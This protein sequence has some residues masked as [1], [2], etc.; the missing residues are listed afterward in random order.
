MSENTCEIDRAAGTFTLNLETWGN[1][2]PLDTLERWLA[3][4]REQRDLFPKS[5]NSYDKTIA[6]LENALAERD[7]G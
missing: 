6:L 7:G 2:Y 3:F 4:Y 1:T 5:R